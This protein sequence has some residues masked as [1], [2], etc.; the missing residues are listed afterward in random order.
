MS[1]N[2][3]YDS[4]TV[5]FYFSDIK[6]YKKSDFDVEIEGYFSEYM[7]YNVVLR[8][9]FKCTTSLWNSTDDVSKETLND[10]FVLTSKTTEMFK[11]IVFET[12]AEPSWIWTKSVREYT[13][14]IL[15]N[16]DIYVFGYPQRDVLKYAKQKIGIYFNEHP[17]IKTYKTRYI[18]SAPGMKEVNYHVYY[19]NE[20]NILRNN[21]VNRELCHVQRT[22]D[23]SILRAIDKEPDDVHIE[24]FK[25]YVLSTEYIDVNVIHDLL[26]QINDVEKRRNV[27]NE[28]K[29]TALF[30]EIYLFVIHGIR[31]EK[32]RD[33]DDD[34][35]L[36]YTIRRYSH[37][38]VQQMFHAS[39]ERAKTFNDFQKTMEY[40]TEYIKS[41]NLDLYVIW[42]NLTNDA[43]LSD[44]YDTLALNKI[45]RDELVICTRGHTFEVSNTF[46]VHEM[47][48]VWC[49]SPLK[50]VVK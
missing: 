15:F 14:F 9:S 18:I 12:E 47:N 29:D 49:E 27:L 45:P 43:Q 36:S 40:W 7:E 11:S 42:N 10:I 23:D 20:K 4:Y 3:D 6:T 21:A 41:Y 31:N 16:H 24:N 30:V 22:N 5:P 19:S 28:L 50:R 44:V 32:E 26:F 8:K 39:I 48:C 25:K 37:D 38:I 1:D 13:S 33:Y 34:S 17:G 35:D 2:D 46:T